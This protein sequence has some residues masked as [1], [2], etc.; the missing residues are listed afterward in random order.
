MEFHLYQYLG[1]IFGVVAFLFTLSRFRKGKLSLGMLALWSGLWIIVILVSIFPNATSQLALA[2]GIGR[3]LDV[4]LILGLIGCYY[5][6]FRMF[7]MMENLKEEMNY[8]IRELA[9][10]RGESGEKEEDEG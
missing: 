9:L 10:Q 6:L 3:G 8:L 4:V 2:S 1:I 5:L 7:N